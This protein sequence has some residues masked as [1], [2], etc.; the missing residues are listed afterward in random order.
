MIWFKFSRDSTTFKHKTGGDYYSNYRIVF[1]ETYI[2][3]AVTLNWKINPDYK[4]RI[5][6]E[7]LFIPKVTLI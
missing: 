3:I 1:A 2:Y 4:S 7:T 6:V 5:A